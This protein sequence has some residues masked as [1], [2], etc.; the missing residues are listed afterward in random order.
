VVGQG[1]HPV[2]TRHEM[3]REALEII[4]ELWK[5]DYVTFH[6]DHFDVEDAKLWDLP[7]EQVR[8]GVAGSGSSSC[9]IAADLGDFF[10]GTEPKPELQEKYRAAGGKGEMVGQLPGCYSVDAKA[11]QETLHEHFKWGTL[12]WKVQAELPGPVNFAAAAQYVRP[13]DMADAGVWGADV[14]AWVE[15]AQG[16]ADAGY[17]R[18]ALVQV[19]SDQEAFCDWFS[20]TLKPALA[21]L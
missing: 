10:I 17:S 12:G 20:S 4:R 19:G 16:F 11:A 15:K 1:W 3:L 14:E 8:I 5:G 7:D 21:D 18:L 2:E 9:A 13:D 6:G